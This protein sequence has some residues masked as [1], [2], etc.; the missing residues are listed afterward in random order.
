M[1][2]CSIQAIH[3][4]QPPRCRGRNIEACC[5]T[6][7]I[8]GLPEVPWK[9]T[10]GG[11]GLCGLSRL[12]LDLHGSA[13]R[14]ARSNPRAMT[15]SDRY[16]QDHFFVVIKRPRPVRSGRPRGRRRLHEARIGTRTTKGSPGWAAEQVRAAPIPDNKMALPVHARCVAKVDTRSLKTEPHLKVDFGGAFASN[17]SRS[18]GQIDSRRNAT[19]LLTG[20]TALRLRGPGFSARV[21]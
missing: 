5:R 19:S 12:S 16:M 4:G 13:S 6:Q 15:P 7:E 8:N 10:G 18:P 17:R 20:N 9:D 11:K 1:I 2:G 21:A 14:R 3:G